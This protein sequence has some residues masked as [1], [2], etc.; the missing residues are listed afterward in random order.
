MELIRVDTQKAYQRLHRLIATLQLAPGSPIDE[1][2]LAQE[3]D[4]GLTPIRE[5]LKLLVHDNLVEV[6]P[7]GGIFVSAVDLSDLRQISELR[8]LLESF[9]AQQAA[10]RATPDDLA[11]LEALR[12]EQAAIPPDDSQRWFDL[13][14]KFHQAIARAAHNKYL[15]QTLERFFGLSQRLWYLALPHLGFLP[16]SVEVHLDLVDAIK[17]RD[18]GRAE[19][20]MSAHVKDFYDRV[21]QIL[22]G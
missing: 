2:R 11:I 15:A 18:A 14:H 7:H 16:A 22:R 8:R 17:N 20:L 6:S 19:A 4:M 9:C 13:D 21:H 5:A 3:L 12:Q 1:G 10:L